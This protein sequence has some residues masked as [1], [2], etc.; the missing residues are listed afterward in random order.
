MPRYGGELTLYGN[1]PGV[2]TR[3]AKVVHVGHSYGSAQTYTLAQQWP[4]SS[5][6]IILTGFT[7]IPNFAPLFVAGSSFVPAK[8][9]S[10][11]AAYPDGEC[12]SFTVNWHLLAFCKSFM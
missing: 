8:T 4:K 12:P 7:Q 2:C 1:R 9:I 11:L 10:A 5:D 6:G 3:F